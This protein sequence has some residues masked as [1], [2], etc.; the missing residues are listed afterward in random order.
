[1]HSLTEKV[2]FVRRCFGSYELQRN[3]KNIAIRCPICPPTT[4]AGKKKLVIRLEDDL[5]HCWV[6]GYKARSLIYLL[7]KECSKEDLKTY[8]EIFYTGKKTSLIDD[9]NEDN[10]HKKHHLPKDFRL[11]ALTTSRDPDI[12]AAKYYCENRGITKRDLWFY[13]IGVSSESTWNRRII[14]PSFDAEGNLNDFLGRAVGKHTYP[15]YISPGHDK[16]NNI[17]NELYID[18]KKQVVLCEGPIDAIKCGENAIPLLGSELN[19]QSRLFEQLVIHQTPTAIALDSDMQHKIRFLVKKLE[20]YDIPVVVVN[21][22]NDPGEMTKQQFVET[23][24]QAKRYTWNN[25]IHDRLK[26][27]INV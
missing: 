26:Q 17:W 16:L 12:K 25:A 7:K 11:L 2:D 20:E 23:L 1:M 24:S 6:C 8:I 15:K 5:C 19:E 18:W 14:I 13:K 10:H 21:V 9:D 22:P 27:F 4:S 3:E